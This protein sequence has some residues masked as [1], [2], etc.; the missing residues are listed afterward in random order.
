MNSHFSKLELSCEQ[1]ICTVLLKAPPLNIITRQVLDELEEALRLLEQENELRVVVVSSALPNIFCAGADI[2]AF[3]SWT[4]E[5][6]RAA[7]LHG[8]NVFQRIARFP[9]PVL[10]AV[11]GNA[12]GAGLELAMACDIRI[13]DENAQVSLPE[14]T[15]GMQP[16]YGGTQRT[17]RLMGPGFAKRML[18]TGEAIDAQTALRVGLAEE[19]APAGHCLQ[20]AMDMARTIAQRAPMAVAQIKKSVSY[21]MDH[22][23]EKGLSF[24]N[25]RIAL[26]CETQDKQE[27]AAAFVQK[28]TAVFRG[29]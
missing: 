24:E 17:P 10:C 25:R 2:K 8:S 14:C 11:S 20:A 28:R 22:S 12:F 5:S 9:R 3:A 29:I 16:G 6:G 23:L 13:F 27:G 26:L 4:G 1:Y 18:F 15:L 19:L 7:C 21:A